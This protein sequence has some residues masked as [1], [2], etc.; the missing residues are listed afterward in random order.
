[1]N[2]EIESVRSLLSDFLFNTYKTQLLTLSSKKQK[3]MME[4][5]NYVDAYITNIKKVI[6]LL[7]G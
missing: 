4:D 3:N 2:N 6:D 1:M 7:E 5:I